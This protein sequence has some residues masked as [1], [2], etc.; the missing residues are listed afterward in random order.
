MFSRSKNINHIVHPKWM[1][2]ISL[3]KEVFFTVKIITVRDVSVKDRWLYATNCIYV[4]INQPAP[5]NCI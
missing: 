3:A 4:Y 2:N 1:S 5:Q